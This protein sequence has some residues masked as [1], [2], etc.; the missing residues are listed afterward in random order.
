[1]NA[2]R[3]DPMG[4]LTIRVRL[5]KYVDSFT[6]SVCGL[7]TPLT[8]CFKK[9]DQILRYQFDLGDSS[10]A[11][12]K[13]RG[14]RKFKPTTDLP[15]TGVIILHNEPLKIHCRSCTKQAEFIT[16]GWPIIGYP[17]EQVFCS[18]EHATCAS[19]DA[20]C[21]LVNTPRCGFAGFHYDC[22][23]RSEDDSDYESWMY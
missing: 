10:Y 7:T 17:T 8:Q 15:R 13:Y 12:I 19:G 3:I 9:H 16:S 6:H 22:T 21:K 1:M 20:L 5:D 11:N 2:R 18:K 14:I 4:E 23:I